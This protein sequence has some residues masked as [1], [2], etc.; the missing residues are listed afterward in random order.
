MAFTV[1]IPSHSRAI[2]SI[3]ILTDFQSNATFPFFQHLHFHSHFQH[4]LYFG[5]FESREMYL[6]DTHSK[7]KLPTY[8]IAILC[9]Y[10]LS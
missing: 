2:I 9:H 1:R 10:C 4:Y 3:P 5:Y 8:I 7:R 6:S